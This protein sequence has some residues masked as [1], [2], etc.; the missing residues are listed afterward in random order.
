MEEVNAGGLV[1]VMARDKE[2]RP[3]LRVVDPE[4]AALAE[5]VR[6]SAGRFYWSWGEEMAP[7]GEKGEAAR[8]LRKVLRGSAAGS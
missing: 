4:V 3:V 1:A 6:C 7:A 5:N 2:R 8:L